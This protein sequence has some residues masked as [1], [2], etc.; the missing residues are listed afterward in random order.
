MSAELSVSARIGAFEQREDGKR[1]RA[2]S[3]TMTGA[4]AST[5]EKGSRGLS[6]SELS[7]R[8][9]RDNVG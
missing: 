4:R 2:T 9:L 5:E 3:G 6:V 7:V 1:M 8:Q